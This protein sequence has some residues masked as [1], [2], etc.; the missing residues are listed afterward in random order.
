MN[1]IIEKIIKII[2]KEEF[3]EID[4]NLAMVYL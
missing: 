3:D 1:D 4:Y 2:E